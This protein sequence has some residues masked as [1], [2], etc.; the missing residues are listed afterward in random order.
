MNQSNLRALHKIDVIAFEHN[1]RGVNCTNCSQKQSSSTGAQS[2]CSL[3]QFINKRDDVIGDAITTC[4]VDHL[5]C[6]GGLFN[7]LARRNVGV[8]LRY[9]FGSRSHQCKALVTTDLAPVRNRHD[10][11]ETIDQRL[12]EFFNAEVLRFG[13]A[14]QPWRIDCGPA[15]TQRGEIF[16]S[17]ATLVHQRKEFVLQVGP[18]AIDFVEEDKL[19]VPHRTR[20]AEVIQTPV[21]IRNWNANEIVVVQE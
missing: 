15:M 18:A 7:Q 11:P 17:Y 20:S 3:C 1:S 8:R 2:Y 4:C 10:E 16:T 5:E 13:I 6:S 9:G 21:V 19:G 12:V 14:Q